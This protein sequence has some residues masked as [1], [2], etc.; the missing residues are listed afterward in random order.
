MW[1]GEK[2]GATGEREQWEE[3][4]GQVS[5]G[6]TNS[7]ADALFCLVPAK[8]LEHDRHVGC[9]RIVKIN[10]TAH[11]KQFQPGWILAL[12]QPQHLLQGEPIQE[13]SDIDEILLAPP[14]CNRFEFHGSNVFYEKVGDREREGRGEYVGM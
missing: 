4:K 10:Q 3:V 2:D 8:R 5:R 1:N 13:K 14:V 11:D 9:F 6:C 7:I 12:I